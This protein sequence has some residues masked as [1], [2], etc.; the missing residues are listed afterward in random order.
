MV[1]DYINTKNTIL[2]LSNH[3]RK[4]IDNIKS[5]KCPIPSIFT[6]NTPDIEL[7][8]LVKELIK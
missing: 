7:K 8:E 3:I 6:L 4:L 1:K 5:K 2:L